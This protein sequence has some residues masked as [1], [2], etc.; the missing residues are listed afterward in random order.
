M[1]VSFLKIK[2]TLFYIILFTFFSFDSLAVKYN[3]FLCHLVRSIWDHFTHSYLRIS[4]SKILNNS[5]LKIS[6]TFRIL[7]MCAYVSIKNEQFIVQSHVK[8]SMK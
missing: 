4:F 6:I 8:V 3:F 7:S 5:E 1:S 2:M